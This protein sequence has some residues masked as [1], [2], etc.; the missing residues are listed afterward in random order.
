M[1]VFI[2]VQV[3]EVARNGVWAGTL[4]VRGQSVSSVCFEERS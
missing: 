1:I 3:Y 4:S 2:V